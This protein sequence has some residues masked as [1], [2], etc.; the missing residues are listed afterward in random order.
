MCADILGSYWS[1][2]QYCKMVN[3]VSNIMA[4]SQPQLCKNGLVKMYSSQRLY[5]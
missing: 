2:I 1:Y 5:K 3:D 4:L